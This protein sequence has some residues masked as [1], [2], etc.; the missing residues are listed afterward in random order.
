[1]LRVEG[2]KKS[3]DGKSNGSKLQKLEAA[4]SK[5]FNLLVDCV[6]C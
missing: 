6:E 4:L 1:M 2:K 3:N 5:S